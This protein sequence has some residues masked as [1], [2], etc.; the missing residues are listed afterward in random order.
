MD[1]SSPMKWYDGVHQSVMNAVSLLDRK[2]PDTQKVY[3]YTSADAAISIIEKGELRSSSVL[4][5]NDKTEHVHGEWRFAEALNASDEPTIQRLRP[6]I[7]DALGEETRSDRQ[8]D[9]YACCFSAEGNQL[10]QWRAYANDGRGYS[11]GFDVR[12]ITQLG[13]RG[14]NNGDIATQA[15]WSSWVEYS[16][17]DVTESHLATCIVTAFGEYFTKNS[18]DIEET[19][20]C[21]DYIIKLAIVYILGFSPM[22]KTAEFIA[23]REFR[24]VVYNHERTF[25]GRIQFRSKNGTIIPFLNLAAIEGVPQPSK[26][27]H[28]ENLG[29]LEYK[30]AKL[31][32]TDITIGPCLEF[33]KAEPS[34]RMLLDQKGYN[35]VKIIRSDIPYWP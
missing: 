1:L 11:I 3:H 28:Q 14:Q 21:T 24:H 34:L 32:I 25:S 35:D 20:E 18:I 6:H 23:E 30:K 13:V 16:E 9:T 12:K 2:L 17:K 4:Y 10:G 22:Q 5:L 29:L 26:D 19:P 7:L 31:P 8:R 33:D 15:G 27:K